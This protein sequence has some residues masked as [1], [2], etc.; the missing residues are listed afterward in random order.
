MKI[1]EYSKKTYLIGFAFLMLLNICLAVFLIKSVLAQTSD[2][3]LKNQSSIVAQVAN[4]DESPLSIRVI[5]VD[6][7]NQDY[8]IVN[9]IVQNTG[10][11]PVR[12]YVI[13][14]AN[15]NTGKIITNFL[16]TKLFELNAV[17]TEELFVER[18]NIKSDKNLLLSVDY[19]KFAD[20]GSW[21]ED[22]QGQ[23]ERIA[24]GIAGAIDAIEQLRKIIEKRET[25]ILRT[26]LK[27][28]LAEV[29]VALPETFRT[30]GENW[31]SGFRT[32]YKSIISF[33][34]SQQDKSD[35]ELLMKLKEIRESL[36]VE[37]KEK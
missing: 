27:K 35:E 12:G 15:K 23:S 26:A 30:K 24:G 10:N 25:V 13:N 20:D 33:L 16:P 28:D 22:T 5:N 34:K 4:Q 2:E 14:G 7:S 8:Q 31:K 1:N 29:E 32:G 9:F 3:K 18:E 21:G 11:K 17:F 6:N 19:V 37:R 36:Q